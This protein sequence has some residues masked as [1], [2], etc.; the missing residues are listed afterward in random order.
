V[1][2]FLREANRADACPDARSDVRTLAQAQFGGNEAWEPAIRDAN[3]SAQEAAEA[4][5]LSSPPDLD[6]SHIAPVDLGGH[7]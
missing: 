5:G 3:A 7:S 4:A 1:V 6:G 2:G